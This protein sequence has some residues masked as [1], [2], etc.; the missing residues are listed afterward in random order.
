[1]AAQAVRLASSAA[2]G[3]DNPQVSG[4]DDML[5]AAVAAAPPQKD[6]SDPAPESALQPQNKELSMTFSGPVASHST[7]LYGISGPTN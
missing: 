5:S 2:A 3:A 1:M 7:R 6:G 4:A